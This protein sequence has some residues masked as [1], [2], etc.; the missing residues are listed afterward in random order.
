MID[1]RCFLCLWAWALVGDLIWWFIE[2]F[3][4]GPIHF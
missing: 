1:R 2:A 3:G 4:L